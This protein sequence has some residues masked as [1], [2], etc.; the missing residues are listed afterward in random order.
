[1]RLYIVRHGKAETDSPT[2]RD[3]DRPLKGRGDKQARY[4]GAW[5][6]VD[7][8]RPAQI[9]TSRFERAFETARLIQEAVGCQLQTAPELE[10]GEPPSKAVELISG[11]DRSPLMIVGHN[12]QLSELIW[13]LTRG[14]PAEEAGL[15]TGEAV[16][17]D[18]D[19]KDPIGSAHELERV[20]M[21]DGE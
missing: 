11:Q 2:G 6:S 10:S 17:L 16:V 3:Q 7:R 1:M 18:V 13:I 14:M 15:R 5:F 20:R 9:I 4:L 19:H 8:R 12:P 21:E